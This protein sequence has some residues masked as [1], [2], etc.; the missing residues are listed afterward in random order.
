MVELAIALS[1]Q[2]QGDGGVLQ[3]GLQNLQ[4]GLQGLQQLAN[5]GQG[6]AGILGGRAEQEDSEGEEGGEVEEVVAVVDG[7]GQYS[8][9]TAS[10]PGSD[11]EG[12]IGVA[13]AESGDQ[14]H[15][16]EERREEGSDSGGSCGESIGA[17]N[18]PVSGRSSA[19]VE[20]T[21]KEEMVVMMETEADTDTDVRLGGLRQVMIEKLVENLSQLRGVGGARCIPY[22][23]IALAMA[24]DL[25]PGDTR[26]QAALASLLAR[27]V[28]ELGVGQDTDLAEMSARSLHR[29]FQLVI[30]RLLSVLMS[31]TR[32]ASL[33]APTNAEATNF[34]S[35]TTA[36]TLAQSG[37]VSH[38]L[39]MLKSIVTYWQSLPQDEGLVLPG[40]KLL[41]P[42]AAYP[43]P[44]M[45]PFFL[46]QYVKSHAYDVFEAYPQLLTEMALRIPYQMK[47]IAESGGEAGQQP[48]PHFDQ[49]WF[50]QL[51]ELM[52]APQAPFVK[53]QVRK[54]LLL[55]CGSKEQYRQLRD[56]HTLETRIREIKITVAKGGFDFADMENGSVSLQYDTLI[57][58]IEQLKTCVEVAESRT[59]NWQRFCMSDETVLPFLLQVSYMLDNG[60]TPLVLQLLQTALCPPA[61]AEKP[62]R[63]KSSSPEKSVRK[64]KS[65]S[66]E[67]EDEVNCASDENLCIALVQQLSSMLTPRPGTNTALPVISRFVE[68]FLLEC[69]TTSVRWQAHALVVSLYNNSA[70]AAR[71]CLLAILWSLWR[72]L[73]EH[74]R[75]A[76]Q[77]VDLLGFF[78]V[79][80]C[81]AGNEDTI[82]EYARAAVEMLRS[83]NTI[84]GSHANSAIYTSLSQLVDFTG[85]YLESDPCLVCNNPEV[86]F[87]NLKLSSLKV[88]T[89]FTTSTQMVKLSGSHS[90]SKI[91]LRIGDLKRQKMVRTINI[92]Y[93]NRTVQAVVE[94]K[95]RPTMWHLAKKITLTSGQVDLKIEFPLPIVACNIMIEY[96]DFYENIQAVGES[97]QCPRCSASVPANPGVCSN[98]GENVFQCHKCRAINYDEKDPFLCNSCGFCK[99]AKFEYSLTARPC[100]AVDPIENEEDRKKALSTINSLLEKADKVYRQLIGNKPELEHLLIRVSDGCDVSQEASTSGSPVNKYIHQ[101]GQ[102]YC[103]ECKNLFED[104]SKLIQ[105]VMATRLELIA[106][107][108][109]RQSAGVAG[110]AEPAAGAGPQLERKLSGVVGAGLKV[111]SSGG[112]IILK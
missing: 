40:C 48:G 34:V 28:A 12:S 15:E 45:A 104:L 22:M 81:R 103:V 57:Q 23:Q 10:A 72:R 73:P 112:N 14:D 47:K 93:N 20:I 19:G 77:F 11:D 29:E 53:R 56:L 54:L 100:C 4:Q 3:Q 49:A 21:K 1:L 32:S 51:C 50:Y 111:G 36:A 89:K 71:H 6:L 25:D 82:A 109:S 98:C 18:L 2:D 85:Y 106:F 7:D 68:K 44:D 79:S 37:L 39:K 17:D 80:E 38:H 35:R 94:L 9:T 31:R 97:L 75:R 91:L 26:D 66:E 99:Y 60:V 63:S 107:D 76:A 95:N 96:S 90:I 108:K 83:Q 41:R 78:S 74:G 102:K 5:L 62:A 46:K 67:P 69:N 13:G 86:S 43:P 8:D 101:L 33:P 105:K 92:Y 88:D 52:I 30:L 27:L 24:V 61:R 87:T 42:A 110:G 65:R 70:P 64:E 16:A 58:L 59:L 55:I 84:L